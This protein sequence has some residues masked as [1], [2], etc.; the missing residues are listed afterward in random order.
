MNC[1]EL[2]DSAFSPASRATSER[3]ALV[4]RKL[5]LTVH[6]HHL[7]LDQE[8]LPRIVALLFLMAVL[9]HLVPQS[10]SQVHPQNCPRFHCSPASLSRVNRTATRALPH[11]VPLHCQYATLSY[12]L[13]I[14]NQFHRVDTRFKRLVP[15]P[16]NCKH[17][18]LAELPHLFSLLLRTSRVV[19]SP[20]S[21]QKSHPLHLPHLITLRTTKKYRNCEPK[22]AFL[23]PNVLTMPV[24][25]A[26]SKRASP[27]PNHLSPFVP[28][29]KR[30]STLSKQN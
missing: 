2:Y 1:S 3:G 17:Q 6:H 19:L 22:F 5:L 23:K 28:S 30:N 9:L 8:A 15:F 14:R 13:S 4:L 16:L 26:S 10:Q 29:S 20:L 12:L 18:L 11:Q 25:F 21:L 24:M 27:K 7:P